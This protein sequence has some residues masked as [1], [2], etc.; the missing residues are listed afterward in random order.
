MESFDSPP[1]EIHLRSLTGLEHHLTPLV[2]IATTYYNFN[3]SPQWSVKLIGPM[4]MSIF[5]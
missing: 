2:S 3:N 5:V 4:K 1:K